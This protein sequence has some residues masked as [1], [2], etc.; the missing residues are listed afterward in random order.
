MFDFFRTLPRDS[1]R[2]RAPLLGGEYQ[3]TFREA[4]VLCRF[5]LSRAL[6]SRDAEL[7]RQASRQP[8]WIVR[9]AGLVSRS[10]RRNSRRPPGLPPISFPRLFH[11]EL[12]LLPAWIAG[13]AM[14]R[15]CAQR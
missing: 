3:R 15:A 13:S 9:R 12:F 4:L 11:S 8:H 14:A 7:R 10:L 6:S 5:R 2:F 1:D